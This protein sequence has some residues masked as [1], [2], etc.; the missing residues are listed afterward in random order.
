MAKSKKTKST[1]PEPLPSSRGSDKEDSMKDIDCG[2]VLSVLAAAVTLIF[3]AWY[4]WP[5]NYVAGKCFSSLHTVAKI[6]STGTRSDDTH[7]WKV[8][9]FER[10]DA[11]GD[12][13]SRWQPDGTAYTA[14]ILRSQHEFSNTYDQPVDCYFFELAKRDY[15]IRRVESLIDS[16]SQQIAELRDKK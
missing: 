1:R 5:S 4:C 15:K 8:V 2:K 13:P 14:D 10:Y 12:L 6:T 9:N 11:W 3:G 7:S 16:L